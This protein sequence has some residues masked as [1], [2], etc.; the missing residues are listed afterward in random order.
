MR[1]AT[2]LC[3]LTLLALVSPVAAIGADPV[4]GA[5][6]SPPPYVQTAPGPEQYPA[7]DGLVLRHVSQWLRLESGRVR[8]EETRAVK[9]FTDHLNRRG[10][11]DPNITWDDHRQRL[12]GVTAFTYTADGERVDPEANSFVANTP[13]PLAWAPDYAHV[14]QQTI[15][16]VGVETGSTSVL[17]YALEDR[18]PRNQPLWGAADMFSYMPVLDRRVVVQ[19]P[20]DERL[21]HAA[22]GCRLEPEVERGDGVTRYV[23]RHVQDGPLNLR[24]PAHPRPAGCQL[25]FST[26]SGWGDVRSFLRTRL[27]PAL[28]ESPA[29]SAKA[30][31]LLGGA[32]LDEARLARL[33]GFVRDGIRTL[34]LPLETFG[35]GIRPAARVLETSAGH[36]LEKAVLLAAL[37]R[38]AGFPADVALVSRYRCR[39]AP[40]VPAPHAFDAP[41][42]VVGGPGGELWIDPLHRPSAKRRAELAGRRALRIG[43][44]TPADAP[45]ETVPATGEDAATLG[46]ELTVAAGED[47]G[48]SVSGLVELD[49]RGRYH[50]SPI[51]AGDGDPAAPVA[52]AL[53]SGLGGAEPADVSLGWLSSTRLAA[54]VHLA[55]GTLTRVA[56]DLFRLELPRVPGSIE[57]EE[58]G[59]HRQQRTLPLAVHGPLS[60][61]VHVHIELP[62]GAEVLHAPAGARVEQGAASWTRTV[63]LEDG[64]LSVTSQLDLEPACVDPEAY[65]GL[66]EVLAASGGPDARAVLIRWSGAN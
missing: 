36:P 53:A 43:E 48:L 12:N 58:L 29:I 65:P 23:F 6:P 62:A 9:I 28:A 64:A 35:F 19:L 56:P 34:D 16:Q 27:R 52:R 14:R 15:V 51:A 4:A 30:D 20:M 49:L 11:F 5:D 44:S 18:E 55:E 57:D 25:V 46:A 31:E 39:P 60:E 37:A 66:R 17:S 41:W 38:A 13:R 3:L 59:L 7:A 50:P 47:E 21:R 26:A 10:E 33:H 2:T 45:P 63:E 42:V 61:S 54:R 22:V 8:H 24:E 32:T 1:Y 40:G